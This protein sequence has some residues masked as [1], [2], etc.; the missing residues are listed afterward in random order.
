MI[1][2]PLIL[3]SILF[4][5]VGMSGL[6]SKY[7]QA[8]AKL[9]TGN[10]SK[11]VASV[12]IDS[13]GF[14][15]ILPSPKITPFSVRPDIQSRHYL[16]ADYNSG[17]I[18]LKYEENEKV[19]IASTT[20]I[21]T[22]VLALENYKLDEIVEVSE[23]ASSQIGA[24]TY[25]RPGEKISVGELLHCLLIKSGNDAAYALAEHM[26]E[27][28]GVEKFVTAMNDRAKE[29]GMMDTLYKDPAG[30][31]VSGY[32]TAKDL[33]TITRTALK[34]DTFSEIT[35]LP[36]YVAKNIDSTIYHQ[37]DNSNRLVNEY[38]YMG[39]IGVKTGYMPEAGHCLVSAVEREG[40]ILIGVILNT[41]ADTPS[42]SAD[43]SRKLQDWGWAN[44][45]WE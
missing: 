2:K 31:D 4:N 24:D 20:K 5:V 36:K 1:E 35:T 27:S 14:P 18:L 3:L 40:H 43:E 21:M 10:N 13:I 33:F 30:L 29:L 23:A 45:N 39:A 16:L 7:D 22:A 42:A 38:K 8:I 12:G 19:P 6:S 28:G 9:E 34:N 44:I 15:E 32:S 11:V 25:L 17:K 26:S 41:Y 37:L